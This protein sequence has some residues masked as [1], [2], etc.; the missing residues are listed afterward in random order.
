MIYDLFFITST[1]KARHDDDLNKD[2]NY[3]D[4]DKL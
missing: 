4:T 1:G 3:Y 2:K